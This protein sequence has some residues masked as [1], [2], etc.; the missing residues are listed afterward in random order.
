L[1]SSE[2][3]KDCTLT[4][5]ILTAPCRYL[6]AVS[7]EEELAARLDEDEATAKAAAQSGSQFAEP[8]G[9]DPRWQRMEGHNGGEIR[10]MC[11]H[12]GYEL[13]ERRAGHPRGCIVVFDEG[14]PGPEQAAHIA[15]HDPARALRFVDAVR[16]IIRESNGEGHGWAEH[17]PAYYAGLNF[18]VIALA[19]AYDED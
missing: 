16:A 4:K 2:S 7:S 11:S 1:S 6:G 9:H 12:P 18:A 10:D 8:G 17:E 13:H 14:A 15:R 19:G 3:K 5:P